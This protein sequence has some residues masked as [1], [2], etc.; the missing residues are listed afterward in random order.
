MENNVTL[1]YQLEDIVENKSYVY[2]MKLLKWMSCV[3]LAVASVACIQNEPLNAEC[4]IVKAS[5]PEDILNREPI[6]E[7]DKVI[8]IVKNHISVSELSPEFELTPGAT[9]EPSSGTVRNFTTPKKYIVTSEDG[10]WQKTYTVE[11]EV[12]N[13]INLNYDFEHVK[14]RVTGNYTYDIFYEVGPAGNEVMTWASGNPGYALTGSPDLKDNPSAFPTYQIDNGHSGKCLALTTRSTGDFGE[15]VKKPMAAG[16][17]FIGKFDILN[18]MQDALKATKFGTPFVNI[19]RSLK[20]YYKYA[21]GETFFETDGKG[22]LVQV[23]GKVDKFNIYAV[24]FEAVKGMEMLDGYNVL[25]ADNANIVAVAEINDADRVAAGEWTS[26]NIPFVYREGKEIDPQEL[27]DGKYSI[28]IVF[29]SSI[30]GDYFS[31]APGSTLLIDEVSLVC[32]N[33]DEL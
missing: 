16:S 28:T 31:G 29:S 13:T 3:L 17:L 5:L 20:G 15:M 7:N 11:V 30:D 24:F 8:F 6:I 19:P 4:D 12:N 22:N 21:P 10:K 26:F 32:L 33:Q 23:P 1:Q 9:I 25:S 27:I 18:A 14:Q 2:K